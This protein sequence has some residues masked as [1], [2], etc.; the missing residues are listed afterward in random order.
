MVKGVRAAQGAASRRNQLPEVQQM[1]FQ[2]I[3]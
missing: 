2:D 1:P 3:Y